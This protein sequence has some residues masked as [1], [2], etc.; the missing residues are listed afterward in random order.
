[1]T[2]EEIC[3]NCGHAEHRNGQV[4]HV[5]GN[6]GARIS[7]CKKFKPANRIMSSD[8]KGSSSNNDKPQKEETCANCGHREDIHFLVV[9]NKYPGEQSCLGLDCEC[10]KFTPQAKD[11]LDEIF[12]NKIKRG[13][14]RPITKGEICECGHVN[15]TKSRG[16]DA[17]GCPC[18]KFKP[19]ILH[20]Q[21]ICLE[22]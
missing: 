7:K 14:G 22:K 20:L 21:D 6:A 5:V 13:Q 2:K 1:M 3:A 17:I 4:Y 9:K 15:H 12:V 16:C 11:P 8:K 19:Q 10:K 18:Q